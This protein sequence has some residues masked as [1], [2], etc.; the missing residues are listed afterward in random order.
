MSMRSNSVQRVSHWPLVRQKN[1][2]GRNWL[3]TMT[4]STRVSVA[5]KISCTLQARSRKTVKPISIAIAAVMSWLRIDIES[6]ARARL[7]RSLGSTFCSKTS[8]LSWNSRERNLPIS[9]YTRSTYETSTSS[10]SKSTNAIP[11]AIICSSALVVGHG[12]MLCGRPPSPVPA[13]QL[14][15]ALRYSSFYSSFPVGL[16]LSCNQSYRQSQCVPQPFFT[17][18][19]FAAITLMVITSEVQQP[20]ERKD[21]NLICR[22]V[23]QSTRVL[24]RYVRGNGNVS[25][26]VFH[27]SKD[28]RKR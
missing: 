25:G 9:W 17:A 5:C 11:T 6:D 19:H 8:I 18:C 4:M 22:R 14:V 13:E 28:W 27:Q 3:N 21:S 2:Y 1:T 26:K 7:T 15:A 16:L 24:G 12:T 10:P 23:P 20:V